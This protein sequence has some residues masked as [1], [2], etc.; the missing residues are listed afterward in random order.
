MQA[1]RK[2]LRKNLILSVILTIMLPLGGAMLGVGLALHQPAIW[3]IGIAFMVCGFYGCP[4]AWTMA[5]APTKS[6]SRI[7]SA[8]VEENLCTV[9]EIA[10]QLSLSEKDVRNRLDMCFRKHYLTGYKGR[11]DRAQRQPRPRKAFVLGGM[12]LLRREICLH[13]GRSPL[14]VLRL[15]RT[16]VIM[17][18]TPAHRSHGA[19]VFFQLIRNSDPRSAM[20]C[21]P[22]AR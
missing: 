12:P 19:R 11:R 13:G 8:V 4:C 10:A 2:A 16:K 6:L 18:K 14:P 15:A 22:F 17:H 5:Y 21:P 7:V 3:A 20:S 9:N 1:V